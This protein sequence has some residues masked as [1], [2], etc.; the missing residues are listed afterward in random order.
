[1]ALP[2]TLQ[3]LNSNSSLP[4]SLPRFPNP[5]RIR[6]YLLR[7]PLFTR[8]M[9]LVIIAFWLAELQTVW[10]VIEWGKIIPDKVGLGTMYRLNT[11]PLV[12]MGFFHMLLDT[13]CLIPL[14]E[15]FE[16]EWGTLTSI[17]L[18]LGRKSRL[19]IP[20]GEEY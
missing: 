19:A 7:L 20:G 9:L 8:I 15:R 2:A 11:Y 18:F 10:S 4:R 13:V 12:H 1:M 5:I 6:T 14:L 17:A 16:S 3:S